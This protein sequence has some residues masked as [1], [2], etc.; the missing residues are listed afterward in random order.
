[1]KCV[2]AKR[3]HVAWFKHT[4]NDTMSNPTL[5]APTMKSSVCDAPSV[6]A[7]AVCT[8]SKVMLPAS[9]NVLYSAVVNDTVSTVEAVRRR[10]SATTFL[11]PLRH[12]LE[13][14]LVDGR[15]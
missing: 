15:R 11:L 14:R 12:R 2:H 7:K 4:D 3:V 8:A 13:P 6:I 5:M 1:M 10:L 9:Y